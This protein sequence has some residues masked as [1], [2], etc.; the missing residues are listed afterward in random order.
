MITHGMRD[1][2]RHA[3]VSR[4]KLSRTSTTTVLLL[5]CRPI[6]L[7]QTKSVRVPYRPP[8]VELVELL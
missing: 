1:H 4:I 7:I 5:F 8:K 6:I 3:S 2:A